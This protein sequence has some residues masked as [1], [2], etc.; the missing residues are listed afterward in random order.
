MTT[1]KN[2]KAPSTKARALTLLKDDHENVDKMFKR[3][4]KLEESDD[5]DEE[6][7]ALIA[8]I[9]AALKAHATIEE[10][11]FYPALH[12][13]LGED[14]DGEANL[15]EAEVEHEHIKTLVEQ[16][17]GADV[18]DELVCA[19]MTVLIEYVRHHV[20]EEE[21]E[22]FPKAKKSGLDLDGLGDRMEERKGELEAEEAPSKPAPTRSASRR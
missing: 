13:A 1:K 5:S 6:M 8:E 14:E 19:R 12:D 2:S 3:F 16:L 10:E 7:T 9:C 22:I 11:I 17:D 18:E 4:E 15:D 20:K 21:G